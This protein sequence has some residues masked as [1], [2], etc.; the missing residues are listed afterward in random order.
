MA[1]LECQSCEV[2]WAPC[3]SLR[4]FKAQA[5]EVVHDSLAEIDLEELTF[6]QE[7]PKQLGV[8]KS[9]FSSDAQHCEVVRGFFEPNLS[10][11]DDSD[12]LKKL[13]I[14]GDNFKAFSHEARTK[15]HDETVYC[16]MK[17][18][19]FESDG[20]SLRRAR[21]VA[22]AWSTAS[23]LLFEEV[24]KVVK[25][26]DDCLAQAIDGHLARSLD[27]AL[28]CRASTKGTHRLMR[29]FA[30]SP[31]GVSCL[32]KVDTYICSQGHP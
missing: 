4:S 20:L 15:C 27:Q 2:V 9:S 31:V 22:Q 21:L 16:I 14:T 25:A 12:G 3:V 29:T 17:S 23:D 8:L 19:C 32:H 28:Q 13:I 26:I 10:K 11:C 7:A 1:M 24:N 6:G 18:V 30:N 5:K